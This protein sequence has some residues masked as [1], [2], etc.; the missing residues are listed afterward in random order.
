MIVQLD[1]LWGTTTKVAIPFYVSTCAN[2]IYLGNDAVRMSAPL[3]TQEDP[4][5]P[6]S[7]HLDK[8]S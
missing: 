8:N 7:Y 2:S 1:E 3:P 4:A 5:L 6:A